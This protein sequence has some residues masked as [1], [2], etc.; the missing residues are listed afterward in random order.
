MSVFSCNC[1]F[2]HPRITSELPSRKKRHSSTESETDDFCSRLLPSDLYVWRMR[3]IRIVYSARPQHR[4]A[5]WP[6]FLAWPIRNPLA[7]QHRRSLGVGIHHHK[8]PRTNESRHVHVR[9]ALVRLFLASRRDKRISAWSWMMIVWAKHCWLFIKVR[10]GVSKRSTS[11]SSNHSGKFFSISNKNYNTT[12]KRR[13]SFRVIVFHGSRIDGDLWR[14]TIECYHEQQ[15]LFLWSSKRSNPLR[16]ERMIG[17]DFDH[18]EAD[19]KKFHSGKIRA[20]CPITMSVM[21]APYLRYY[22]WT[23][24]KH[25][26]LQTR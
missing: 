17:R 18:V 20:P 5:R 11:C 26:R 14:E 3:L 19:W 25:E 24:K 7:K 2:S 9:H 6:M 21:L 15:R 22:W 4:T 1:I 16:I 23:T 12:E 13:T 10:S 8:L